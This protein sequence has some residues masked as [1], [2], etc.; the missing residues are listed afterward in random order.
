MKNI[1]LIFL[2]LFVTCLVGCNENPNDVLQGVDDNKEVI[3]EEINNNDISEEQESKEY[4]EMTP[5]YSYTLK[6]M[7]NSDYKYTKFKLIDSSYI[8][9][10]TGNRTEEINSLIQKYVS[11]LDNIVVK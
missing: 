5:D 4:L 3:N 2:I 6:F 8:E 1:V 10:I 11:N 7:Q 9:N